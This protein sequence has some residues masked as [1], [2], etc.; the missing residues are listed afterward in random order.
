M[1]AVP[2]TL[3]FRVKSPNG[4]AKYRCRQ[5][6]IALSLQASCKSSPVAQSG[7]E[8]VRRSAISGC[9]TWPPLHCMRR[10]SWSSESSTTWVAVGPSFARRQPARTP[11]ELAGVKTT[12]H[13]TVGVLRQYFSAE[14]RT[15][16][17][18]NC[19]MMYK[20][21]RHCLDPCNSGEH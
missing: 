21:P 10:N 1:R 3:N 20:N 17:E 9:R 13:S 6:A 2:M 16:F 14:R 7:D 18:L 11:R 8:L 4:G 15:G 5:S 12:D 19:A